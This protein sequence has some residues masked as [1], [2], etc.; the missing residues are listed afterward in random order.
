MPPPKAQPPRKR[1]GQRTVWQS[2]RWKAGDLVKRPA[3]GVSLVVYNKPR[4]QSLR[5]KGQQVALESTRVEL[6]L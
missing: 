4:D 3:D 6:C 1:S 2:K 5:P